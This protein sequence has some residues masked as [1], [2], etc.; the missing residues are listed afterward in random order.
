VSDRRRFTLSGT[1]G[2]L[3]PVLLVAALLLAGCRNSVGNIGIEEPSQVVVTE[4]YSVVGEEVVITRIIELTPTPTPQPTVPPVEEQQG[5]VTLDIGFER[6][7]VPTIDPQQSVSQ[8]GIDL[9]ENLFVGLTRYNHQM[10][11]VE[12]ALAESWEVSDNGRVWT[13]H[14]RDDIYWVK[15][16]DIQSDGL[17]QVQPVRPVT[18]ND[19]VFAIQRA[20]NSKPYTPDAFTL[21]IIRGCE[22]ANTTPNASPADLAR[23]GVVALNDSTV[24]FTLTKPAA[25]FLTLTSLWFTRPLS[26]EFVTALGDE[27]QTTEWQTN[28]EHPFLTSGPYVPLDTEFQT[29]QINPLWPLPRQ[30]NVDIINIYYAKEAGNTYELFEARQLDLINAAD[31]DIDLTDERIAPY[32]QVAPQQTLHYLGFNADSGIFREPE[33]RRAF[34]AAIDREKL[35]TELFGL[36][37]MGMRHLIPP[38]A[39]AS[40]PINEVGLGYSPDFARQ[41]LAVSGFG[42]CQLIPPFIFMV[43]SSDLSLQQAELIR[44][45]WIDELGC[46]EDQINIEQVQ[47][48]VLLANTH[49]NAGAA[50]PDV[51]ELAWASF[52][53]DAHNWMGDLLHCEDSENRQNRPCG[54]EDDLIRQANTTLDEAERAAIYR[55]LENRFFG[56]AGLMP[57]TPLYIRSDLW[58]VQSWLTSY[59]PALFGGEQYD[60]YQVDMTIKELERS[61]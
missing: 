31:L 8:D 35:V 2:R 57:L 13:F 3:I 34:A 40:L 44:H 37:A 14:L 53:P 33:V 60:T 51:F 50:R 56:D 12:P 46:T 59:T 9:I 28:E 49:R 11:R 25:H 7:S 55:E 36:Q 42:N 58:L 41:Q 32:L 17:A 15:P 61:R 38:G 16:D 5:P 48:G 39:V 1:S 26:P 54:E 47:F 20:C 6:E 10:N 18:A 24:E 52:Y 22:H 4:V 43:S 23:I 21:F 45:M 29:L 30:G 27:W 19:V